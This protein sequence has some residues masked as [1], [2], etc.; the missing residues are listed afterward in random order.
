MKK[1]M[2]L[3][4]DDRKGSVG[5]AQGIALAIGDRLNIKEKNLKYNS[6]GILPNWLRGKTL[7]G[8]DRRLSDALNDDFPDIVM[9]ISRRTVPVARYI[10]KKSGNRTKIVQ[11]MY[12][13]GGIGLKEMDLV[14]V[15]QHDNAKKQQIPNA[16]TI[17]GAPTKIFPEKLSEAKN[18]WQP[19]FSDLPRPYTAVIIG[20]AI[21][22]RPWPL[23]NAVDL[24]DNIKKI[25]DQTG[26]SLLITTSRRTGK[27]A[28]DI[29]MEKL[30][31]IPAY[32][33]IWG[34]KK[35]NPLLG[36]Y[37]CAD[38]IITTADSVSMCSEACG[39]GVP[40]LLYQNKN[41]LTQ[42]HLRFAESLITKGMATD[43]HSDNALTFHPS[44]VLNEAS[45]IADK[46]LD[47]L[48]KD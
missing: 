20:G 10:R 8:V 41:W 2:W 34:E 38:R 44:S 5:Q 21:K 22:G 39:T 29:I 11:L 46:I 27:E 3:L 42:K 14:V 17:L 25:I 32:T 23:E 31:G 28:Q 12:P 45:K 33:Y 19:V 37:A 9:S 47:I 13:D 30:S 48:N 15:P 24:A 35:E 1:T 36:F 6:L 16:I 7:L 26:G 4:L 43:I 40:V 18:K